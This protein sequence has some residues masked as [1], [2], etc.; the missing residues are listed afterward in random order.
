MPKVVNDKPIR[1]MSGEGAPRP[2]MMGI[3]HETTVSNLTK[4]IGGLVRNTKLSAPVLKGTAMKVSGKDDS[5]RHILGSPSK[6]DIPGKH[7]SQIPYPSVFQ[8]EVGIRLS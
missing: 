8:S 5:D 2:T 4:T 7:Y 6:T 1:Q 3:I